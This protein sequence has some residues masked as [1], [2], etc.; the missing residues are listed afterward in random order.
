MGADKDLMET[1]GDE[2]WSGSVDIRDGSSVHRTV[3]WS[4]WSPT[5]RKGFMHPACR[6]PD[7][8]KLR[9][10][11]AAPYLNLPPS[12]PGADEAQGREAEERCV[13]C[14]LGDDI[15]GD[16]VIGKSPDVGASVYTEGGQIGV[17]EG[18]RPGERVSAGVAYRHCYHVRRG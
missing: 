5:N 8:A 6:R 14:W 15:E 9:R 12:P 16:G 4:R 11:T 10:G 13:G 3:G 17:V 7:L 18:D 2:R 1:A